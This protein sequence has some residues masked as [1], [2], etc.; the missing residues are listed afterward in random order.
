MTGT[1]FS[2]DT[3]TLDQDKAGRH[4]RLEPLSAHQARELGLIFASIDPW[5]KVDWPAER[6]ESFLGGKV[7]GAPRYLI[8]SGEEPAGAVAVSSPW[9]HGAYLNF[10]GIVPG[11]QNSGI[12]TSV[13]DWFEAESLGTYR[14]LWICV[15]AFNDSATRFYEARGYSHAAT[16]DNLIVEG[17]DEILLRKRL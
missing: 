17:E 9:L 6:L 4:V 10:L 12:G 1:P 14:N 15:S 11:L 7:P 2:S 5:K 3:Y 13:M 16:L 8:R